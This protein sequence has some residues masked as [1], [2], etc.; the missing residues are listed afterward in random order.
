MKIMWRNI[1]LLTGIIG[2]IS[3]HSCENQEET[4]IPEV[5]YGSLKV[6]EGQSGTKTFKFP[7]TLSS[8]SDNVITLSYIT[9]DSTARQGM[10]YTPVSNGSLVIPAGELTAEIDLE[11]ISDEILEFTEIF[12]LV[13]QN[14][15]NAKLLL[16]EI[17]ITITDDDTHLLTRDSDGYTSPENYPGLATTWVDEFE[18]PDFNLTD[19]TY[20]LG[21]G[22]W[23]NEELQ[24]YTS[25]PDNLYLENGRLIIK[26]IEE[27][28]DAYTSARVITKGKVEFTYGLIDIRAKLPEGQGIWP[29]LWM[30]GNDIDQVSWPKCGEID[31]MELVGHIPYR[32]HGT[33]HYD[34]NGH[35]Y[36]GGSYSID[37][38]ES[39]SDEFHVFS[40][41]WDKEIITWYVDYE[42]FYQL[43]LSD[44]GGSWPFNKP[45]FFIF[46]IAVGGR[47]PGYPDETTVFP[48]T[49]EVDYIRVFRPVEWE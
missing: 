36:K 8:A 4:S 44:I 5:N 39:F 16:T 24:T 26:A 40:V 43:K 17:N 12:K 23:G 6:T 47:W 41:L 37:I 14:A 48:Q 10:D 3:L 29:A 46:N 7:V 1:I 34:Q 31:I 15:D 20:E 33:A 11:I 21:A 27:S 45:F 18:G 32:S 30:L 13:F 19:W 25:T 38:N 42:K 2:I 9:R 28:E 22:G 35:Q 49:M